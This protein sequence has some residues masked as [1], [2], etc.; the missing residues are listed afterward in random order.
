MSCAEH[1]MENA[2]MAIARSKT[3]EEWIKT[4]PN[5]DAVKSDLKEIWEMATY[6]Y[7]SIMDGMLEEIIY[8]NN[9]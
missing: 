7:S 3:F 6:I 2:L 5:K 9:S 4:E 1:I 8:G